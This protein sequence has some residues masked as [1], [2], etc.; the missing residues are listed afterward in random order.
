MRFVK[1]FKFNGKSLL[2]CFSLSC[3]GDEALCCPQR[4][5]NLTQTAGLSIPVSQAQI[6][7]RGLFVPLG[8][9]QSSSEHNAEKFGRSSI[10]CG[11]EDTAARYY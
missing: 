4:E 7:L 1:T 10:M 2:C 8:Q 6:E 9:T 5:D 3:F 11:A